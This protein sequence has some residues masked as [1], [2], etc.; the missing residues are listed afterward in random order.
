[1]AEEYV[2]GFLPAEKNAKRRC[3][4]QDCSFDDARSV[5]EEGEQLFLNHC[6]EIADT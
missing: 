1:M 5:S 4:V 2:I 3:I 6:L